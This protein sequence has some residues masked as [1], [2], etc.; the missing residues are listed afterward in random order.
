MLQ[1]T[2][3]PHARPI[4]LVS[5]AA[6]RR[7]A[8]AAADEASDGRLGGLGYYAR[9][10]LIAWPASAS[11]WAAFS[12]HR[13]GLSALP[14]SGLHGGRHRPIA[15]DR[16]A[17]VRRQCRAGDGAPLRGR[18]PSGRQA[19]LSVSR[20]SRRRR[21]PRDWRSAD[22]LGATICTPTPR[23]RHLPALASAR[24]APGAPSASPRDAKP[25][26][27]T[28]RSRLRADPRADVAV[29]RPPGPLGGIARPAD[30]DWR[31]APWSTR[32]VA[33]RRSQPAGNRRRE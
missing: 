16:P 4:S 31:S 33:P 17:N 24:A 19:E 1:Q 14:A 22:D 20:G 6:G 32:T 18:T 9:P 10:Q 27:R 7:A 29:R 21:P 23:L 2:T 13:G 25:D 26:R 12:Q 5:P 15:F 3:V 30:S 11:A 8:L 28:L